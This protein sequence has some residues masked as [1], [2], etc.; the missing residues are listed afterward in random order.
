MT[1]G[2]DISTTGSVRDRFT[3]V[4]SSFPDATA[5]VCGEERVSYG[6]LHVR[7]S[8]RAR[9][10]AAHVDS[11]PVALDADSDI[12][13]LTAFLA[14]I[15]AG[16]PVVPLDSR[17]PEERR[18][19]ICRRSGAVRLSPRELSALP[20]SPTTELPQIAPADCAVLLFTS[21]STG[22]PKAVRQGHRLW[23]NQAREFRDRLGIGHGDR[24]GM[25]LPVGFG[26]G[27]D[28][29][30]SALLGGA[31]LHMID[32][33]GSGIDALP[34][35][36]S[37]TD[38]TTLHAT[39]SLLRAVLR[40]CEDDA[41]RALR[42][43]TTCGEPIHGRDVRALR[44]R[45]GPA[46]VYVNLYGSSETGNLAFEE[47]GPDRAIPDRILAA[48]TIA[49]DKTVRLLGT[50]GTPVPPGD[51]G[52]LVVESPWL[53]EGYFTGP[54][55]ALAGD[56]DAFG[57]TDDGT[58]FFRTGD[59]GRFDDDGRLHLVGRRDD[60]V[61]VGGYLVEPDE[62]SSALRT[63]PGVDDAVVTAHR[64]GTTATLVGYVSVTRDR[65]APSPADLRR[66]LRALLPSWMV[67]PHV[68]LLPELPRNERGKVDRGALP[69]PPERPAH[70]P[71]NP[72]TESV[73][74][75]I[76]SEILGVTPIGRDDDFV[77]L[78]GDSL[79]TQQMLTRVAEQFA[80]PASSATLAHH[81]TLWRFAR[82]L[83]TLGRPDSS[84]GRSAQS[85]VLVPLQTGGTR[86]PVFAF[87]G[88]GSTALAL[89]PLARELGPDQPVYGLQARGLERRGLP[90]WTIRSAARR[91]LRHIRRVQPTGPY[92]FVGHSLGGVI[93]MEVARMLE[94][95]GSIV[96]A[97]VCLDTILD[98]PLTAGGPELPRDTA[99]ATT[100]ATAAA[101]PGSAPARRALWRTRAMLLTAG[102]WRYPAETQWTLFHDLG[103]RV[104]LL[105][106]FSPWHGPVDIVMAEDNPDDPRWWWMLAP[107]VTAVHRV[108]G[109]HVGMLRPPHVAATAAHVRAALDRARRGR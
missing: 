107:G 60:A 16:L 4:A 11:R 14:V 84:D 88:A 86:P 9:A 108:A 92:F 12:D 39:P 83:D 101:D 37:A 69:P 26:G 70:I 41:L 63:L 25:P 65:R 89:L 31:E 106:R 15:F 28:I 50:D 97:V 35:W 64:V 33:R 71:P 57:V 30:L 3:Q 61:K 105:H 29:V 102:L 76:W 45:L 93:A 36:L 95:R 58:R 85:S 98:G 23:L 73:L 13:Y 54:D 91:Y 99:A 78:G 22:T 81:P 24:V 27:I 55:G 1:L 77:S 51:V 6:T 19:D 72:G 104:A 79:Q 43:V 59:L 18:A 103:R 40:V 32:P 109:D 100:A 5:V 44:E 10:L 90:D 38:P 47:F 74:A 46:A 56:P 7:V 94:R 82:H 17:L 20:P 52:T 48:G 67:P 49:A 21:G 75:A 34:G 62:V 42:L 2:S 66:E 68:V 80:L 87:A 96:D 53:A 8:E